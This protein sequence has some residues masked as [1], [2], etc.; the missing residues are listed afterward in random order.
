MPNPFAR[1]IKGYGA[2][3][4]PETALLE[5]AIKLSRKVPARQDL[6]REGDKPGPVYVVLD[7]WACRYKVLPDGSRQIMAFLIPGDFCDLHVGVLDEM[8]HTIGTITACRIA[9]IP[10]ERMEALVVATPALTHAFWRAQLVDEGVLR[11]WIV[12]IGRRDSLERFA[13][14]MLELYIRMFNIGLTSDGTCEL[15]LTQIVL[16]D[17]LGLTPVHV[18]RV[19]RT[20][21]QRKIMELGAGTLS[22]PDIQELVRIAGF[23][24]N[25]LHR[26]TKQPV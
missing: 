3:S 18:N 5:D 12:S 7:G 26:R 24:D 15:P 14:L 9:T 1:K 21:R 13:H 6:I 2:L 4:E 16:A 22:I 23:D 20:L 11:A 25:Y 10:R 17:A 19:L 8:D